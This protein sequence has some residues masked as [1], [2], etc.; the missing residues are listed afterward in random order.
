MTR[1]RICWF[2][3]TALLVAGRAHAED[4]VPGGWG[5][6][7]RITFPGY[8]SAAALTNFPVL[9]RFNADNGFY[10][11]FSSTNGYDLRFTDA[12]GSVLSHEVERWVA[13][14]D[15]AVWV[16]V[17]RLTNGTAIWAYWGQAAAAGAPAAFTT[18]G[19]TWTAGYLGVWHLDHL[20]SAS[21]HLD[22]T[23]AAYHGTNVNAVATA[24]NVAGAQNFNSA[25]VNTP[26][27]IDQSGGA[28]ITF[29]AWVNPANAAG[30][31]QHVLSSDNGGYDWALLQIGAN[32]NVA[33]GDGYWNTGVPVVV[34]A[35]QLVAAVFIPGTGV[36]FYRNGVESTLASLAYDASDNN[37][38]I[39][40]NPGF[41]EYFA[42]AI[43]EVCVAGV[44]RSADW[45]QA[46]YSNQV[47]GSTFVAL[48]EPVP[49][50]G[51]V[52]LP[53]TDLTTAS[54][55]LNGTV[56]ASDDPLYVSVYWSTIDGGT[57]AAAWLAAPG[58]S[59]DLG[60]FSNVE[61]AVVSQAVSGLLASATCYYAFHAT[62]AVGTVDAW[63]QPSLHFTPLGV[64]AINNAA[65]A[66]GGAE[67]V[68]LRG[69]LTA[70]YRAEVSV[71]WGRTD[72]GMTTN[73]EHVIPLG[74]RPSDAFQTVVTPALGFD[75]RYRCFAS[76]AYGTAWAPAAGRFSTRWP[77]QAKITFSGYNRNETLTNFPALV[78]LN[79]GLPG[80]AYS[81]CVSPRGYDLRFTDAAG[82][83]LNYEIEKW[84]PG[85]DSIVWVQVPRL[86]NSCQI[87]AHWGNPY[88]L[89]PPPSIVNGATWTGAGYAG[90]WHMRET[91][92]HHRDSTA[93]GFDTTSESVAQQGTAP[94]RIDGADEFNGINTEVQVPP[95]NLFTNTV[96]IS[97]WVNGKQNEDYSGIFFQR[98]SGGSTRAGI[99]SVGYNLIYRWNDRAEVVSLPLP[100]DQWAFV[101]L[102]MTPT[103]ATLYVNDSSVVDA[104]SHAI[105][106]FNG[107]T[108]IGRWWREVNP[109]RRW[110]GIIDEVRIATVTHSP[111]WLWA[112]WQ[113][114]LSP[115]LFS[116]FAPT[117]VIDN[118]NGASD[119]TTHA[120]T[121]N[122][123]LHW[124]N[125]VPTDV[126][127]YWG[128]A[129]AGTNAGD[130]EHEVYLGRP[131]VGPL[132]TTIALVDAGRYYYRFCASNTV[133]ATW[134]EPVASFELWP[135]TIHATA[136]TTFVVSRPVDA[137][138]ASLV[139]R[140]TLGGG[141]VNG[142]D[143]TEL[144][145]VV[146]IPADETEA[147]IPV[148]PLANPGSLAIVRTVI[149]TLAPGGHGGYLIGSPN[150]AMLD[151]G[152]PVAPGPNRLKITFTGYGRATP[153]TNFPALVVLNE[154]R[155]GF[156]YGQFVSPAG[157]DLRFT[158]GAQTRW[159]SYEIDEWNT[160]GDSYVWVKVPELAGTNTFIW[161]D[162][163]DP[164]ATVPAYA[165]NGST[166]SQDHALVY[167]FNDPN[168]NNQTL[169]DDSTANRHSGLV[170]NSLVKVQGRVGGAVQFPGGSG[171]NNLTPARRIDTNKQPSQ[172]GV[173]GSSPRTGEAWVRVHGWGYGG[174]FSMG[175]NDV[176]REFSL[177]TTTTPDT[178][179]AQMWGT[180]DFDFTT[181]GASNQWMHLALVSEGGAGS[182]Q[183]AYANGQEMTFKA[184]ALDIGDWN[185]L[186][187]G[188]WIDKTRWWVL[189]GD[190]DEARLSRV[191]RSADWIWASWMV[192][193][194]HEAFVTYE[195]P[196][197]PTGCL[198]IVR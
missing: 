144:S 62:N 139:V 56:S 148:V 128:L 11:G 129:D 178:W 112:S 12:A 32:W 50:L 63:G 99:A 180:P 121:L 185:T 156:R 77:H 80:F 157:D 172:L 193:G 8:V 165:T 65:G 54:A 1:G 44:A 101:A 103:A 173:G 134:A 14:G 182:V 145:G 70:G 45:I 26:L 127:V 175:T 126:S 108:Y 40:R 76:N 136:P 89:D 90:V 170:W 2:A 55:T 86:T 48:S 150:A 46:S 94:G 81:E 49:V 79:E 87:L 20:N 138:G 41:G 140:Y 171:T 66:V 135:V 47:T 179:R 34:G 35:W 95:L 114:Q 154:S 19:A 51:V 16:Q 22:S 152:S 37:L 24:G 105:E 151:L 188:I 83:S 159:L 149:A 88:A 5:H 93:H 18:N 82:S 4:L 3:L 169:V 143:Y 39:G 124:T 75:Y 174:V 117:M 160:N 137:T 96:T 133:S 17:P 191:A 161:A 130:W 38:A 36:R 97:A 131:G 155:P 196:S 192:Q 43:D 162:W 120:A 30:G 92:G 167:H 104:A 42:G 27:N 73:W 10:D 111:N 28:A 102:A 153:L 91:S 125:A 23:V 166:W 189:D 109:L 59:A 69:E 68:T 29:S 115:A 33:W 187:F 146:T 67:V 60:C 176:A 147:A 85:A 158:D 106:E 98:D 52:N 198:L 61:G 13:G 194:A 122:G 21:Q 7:M 78:V 9:V 15:S 53:A 25:S 190:M 58:L 142:V 168:F 132:A 177:R 118:A 184:D 141:A 163:G 110:D 74:D 116:T 100:Q 6:A 181:P 186:K 71:Y 113:N 164:D 64:P 197:T 72:G 123:R 84:A 107:T 195:V 31:S 57:N 119:I 183:R